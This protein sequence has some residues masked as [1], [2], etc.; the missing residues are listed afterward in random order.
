M[1]RTIFLLAILTVSSFT[2]LTGVLNQAQAQAQAKDCAKTC[3]EVRGEGGELI[4]TARRDPVRVAPKTPAPVVSPSSTPSRTAA[5]T[6][7]RKVARTARPT[8]SDQIREILPEGRFET[9]PRSGALIHEPLLVRAFGCSEFSKILPILDTTIELELTPR[10]TWFWGDG[11]PRIGAQGATR[12]AHIFTRA[13]RY[14]IQMRCEWGGRFRTPHS[15]WAPIPSGI[16]S[17][18]SRTVELFRAQVFFT[19]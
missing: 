16:L 15:S 14:L 11:T 2:L 9:A 7:K 1:R 18:S 17:N 5:A 19:Q 13:G 3:V 12:N 10:I 4:I 8:F 6:P